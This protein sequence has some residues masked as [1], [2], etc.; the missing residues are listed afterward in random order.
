MRLF[1][2]FTG[3]RLRDSVETGRVRSIVGEF[4]PTVGRAVSSFLRI[5]LDGTSPEEG[6][7]KLVVGGVEALQALVDEDLMFGVHV[8]ALRVMFLRKT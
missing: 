7:G 8:V 2:S 5:H 3:F 1:R 6:G 4:A